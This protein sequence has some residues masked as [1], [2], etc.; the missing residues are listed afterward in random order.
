M[1]GYVGPGALR[2]HT[3]VPVGIPV[4]TG[5]RD[6]GEV[7]LFSSCC[8]ADPGDGGRLERK[9]RRMCKLGPGRHHACSEVKAAISGRRRIRASIPA[10]VPLGM[11]KSSS[12]IG[13]AALGHQPPGRAISE[14]HLSRRLGVCSVFLR[15]PEPRLPLSGGGRCSRCRDL[16][17]P[18][19]KGCRK[20]EAS[21]SA[22]DCRA[23]AGVP[24]RRLLPMQLDETILG[25]CPWRFHS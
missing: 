7:T 8:R 3:S 1:T 24:R 15:N 4:L 11:I 9:L 12:R 14:S 19:R 13:P 2:L 16:G 17:S 20:P 23:L 5:E 18:F 21:G 6:R 22:C 10:S 25:M